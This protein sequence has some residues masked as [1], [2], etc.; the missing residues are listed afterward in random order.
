[1]SSNIT[2]TTELDKSGLAKT[3]S[4]YEALFARIDSLP[5]KKTAE[6]LR[7]VFNPQTMSSRDINEWNGKMLQA[8]SA[9]AD[10]LW[11]RIGSTNLNL[12]SWMGNY[13]LDVAVENA[14]FAATMADQYEADLRGA[15]EIVLTPRHRV[16]RNE[17]EVAPVRNVRRARSGSAGRA[18]AGA[19]SVGSALGAALTDRRALGP[20]EGNLLLYMALAAIGGAVVAVLWPAVI[21]WPL[22]FFGAWAGLAWFAKAIALK[23]AEDRP[24]DPAEQDAG[25][26]DT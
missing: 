11:A 17:S 2:V 23:R 26:T 20:A 16:R 9:V 19:L 24:R 8:K 4:G 15:T 10:R 13:E 1:M 22:A 14:A 7:Q 18:A 3:V 12:A 25:S 21:G 6:A 5:D